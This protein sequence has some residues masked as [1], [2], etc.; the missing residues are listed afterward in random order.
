MCIMGIDLSGKEENPSGICILRGVEILFETC[1]TDDEI[2]ETVENFNPRLIV[3]DAPLSLP[4]G[5]CCLEKE[6]GCASGGH[7]HLC[8][9][10]IRRY[11]P[12]LPVTF[13][14]M[15]MLTMK[16]LSLNEK[17]KG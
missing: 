7:F 10:E 9:V 3:I 8:E 2:I 4:R 6:C 11:G 1:F 12:V 15:K 14:G 17:L 5:R 16:G 13:H